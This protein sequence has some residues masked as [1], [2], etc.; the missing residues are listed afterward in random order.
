M[1]TISSNTTNSNSSMIGNRS[2]VLD[3][4]NLFAIVV[5]H[6]RM[7]VL[8][9]LFCSIMAVVYALLVTPIYKSNALIQVED[10]A[11]P[12]FAFEGIDDMF[13][14]ESSTDTEIYI[15]QSR[16]ILGQTVDDLNLTNVIRSNYFPVFGRFFVRRHKKAE[17]ADPLLGSSFAWGG[18]SVRLSEFDV[19]KRLL[20]KE[21]T[22][23]AEGGENY[24]LWLND[25]PILSGTVGTTAVN[26]T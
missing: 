10:T 13:A 19:S 9:T 14:S 15:L 6:R 25:T 11:A 21:F 8:I 16:F 3:L 20:M 7:I 23:V 26:E 24:S 1:T 5:D 22:L 18:E 2:E 12:V 4:A 17:L